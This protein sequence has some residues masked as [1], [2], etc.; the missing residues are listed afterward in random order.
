MDN[1][2]IT[3]STRLTKAQINNIIAEETRKYSATSVIIKNYPYE[4]FESII[5]PETINQMY[6]EI[7]RIKTFAGL[8]LN[9]TSL[10]RLEFYNNEITSFAGLILPSSLTHFDCS[11]NHITSFVGLRLPPSLTYFDCSN[12][13]ITSFAGLKLPSSLRDFK[14]TDNEIISFSG[15]VLPR[16][17][18]KFECLD[19]IVTII[20]DFEFPSSL[21]NLLL[22]LKIV[23]LNPKFNSVLSRQLRNAIVYNDMLEYENLDYYNLLFIYLNFKLDIEGCE[24]LIMKLISFF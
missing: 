22:D 5:F 24:S 2:I 11:K 19:N 20:E 4:D 15:L 9:P 10:V 16:S 18:E 23:F 17:L 3:L 1:I 21:I 12:N 8:K 14:C 13:Q 7:G 6:F